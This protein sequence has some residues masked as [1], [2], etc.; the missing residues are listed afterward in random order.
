MAEKGFGCL[1]RMSESGASWQAI[2]VTTRVAPLVVLALCLGLV[3]GSTAHGYVYWGNNCGNIVGSLD[4]TIGRANL[5]GSVVDERFIIGVQSPCFPT[6]DD[7]YLYWGSVGPATRGIGRARLDGTDLINSFLGVLDA[8]SPNGVDTDGSYLYYACGESSVCGKIARANVDGTNVT[9][10]FITTG[11]LTTPC[12]VAVDDTH[13]WWGS[14][15]TNSIGRANIDG[16]N[17]DNLFITGAVAPCGVVSDGT[18]VVW[19]NT[20]GSTIGIANVD[21]TEVDQS[22]ITG[23]NNPCGIDFDDEHLYWANKGN[24]TIARASATEID[25]SFITGATKPCGVVVDSR[26]C[27]TAPPLPPPAPPTPAPTAPASVPVTVRGLGLSSVVLRADLARDMRSVARALR[28]LG[29]RRIQRRRAIAHRFTPLTAGRI[30]V[31]WAAQAQRTKGR[32]IVIARGSAT[33]RAAGPLTV[34][35]KLTRSGRKLIRRSRRLH[36][37]LRA[38]FRP[39]AGRAVS[40]TT[41]LTLER[42]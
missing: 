2:G 12:G 42:H 23:A 17:A 28:R 3:F 6:L 8:N 18:N 38:A 11:A 13:V 35:V 7:Q 30:A 32:S 5:D 27:L 9:P 15:A 39:Q 16:T 36:M 10:D 33:A 24:G 19:T 37:V 22:F 31:T 41:R 34:A 29:I 14:P 21:G 26:C 40:A 25:Q 1:R 20:G 4:D